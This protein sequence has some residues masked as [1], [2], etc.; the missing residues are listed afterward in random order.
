MTESVLFESFDQFY[1]THAISNAYRIQA[2]DERLLSRYG[3]YIL[4]I[5]SRGHNCYLE[6]AI[7][8]P[9][10]TDLQPR[11]KTKLPRH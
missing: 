11:E 5:C 4:Y 3:D 1:I 10:E 7:G 2:G 8:S 9:L 6:V